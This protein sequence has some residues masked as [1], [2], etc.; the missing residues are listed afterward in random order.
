MTCKTNKKDCP[1]YDNGKCMFEYTEK[2]KTIAIDLDGTILEYH[3]WM[4]HDFFGRPIPGA[5][6]ALKRLKEKGFV[7]I[8]WT[9]RSNKEEIAEYLKSQEIPFDYI[10]ENPYGPPDTSN[11]IYADY[12]V[13]DR[14]IEFKGNWDVVLRKLGVTDKE[15]EWDDD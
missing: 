7:I 13:D 15:D 4:G 8:I 1:Y 10:N 6:K 14:A 3:G 11:K 9:T 2:P 12:Y 5:I